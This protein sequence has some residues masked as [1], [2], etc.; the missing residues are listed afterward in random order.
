MRLE[1][2]SKFLKD[3]FA[4]SAS[5]TIGQ[6]IIFARGF[7]IRRI[8]PP[9]VMGFWNF[10][11]VVQGV[12]AAFDF[13]VIAGANRELPIIHGK[14][15]RQEETKIRSATLWSTFAQ[16]A[17]VSLGA[18]LYLWYIHPGY[19]HWELVASYVAIALFFVG[20]LDA[21]YNVFFSAAQSFSGLSKVLL[22]TRVLEGLTFPLAAY[23]FSLNGLFV[24]AVI[25]A[26]LKA[27]IFLFFGRLSHY[28][29][30]P[31]INLR[32]LKSLLAFG[33]SLRAVDFPYSFFTMASVL[34]VTKFMGIEELAIFSMARGF[35]LQVYD[36]SIQIGVVFAM[37][38]L[39]KSGSDVS[40]ETIGRDLKRY[41]YFQLLVLVPLLAW[42]ASVV[43]PLMVGLF[44]P[45]YRPGIPALV[46]ML[47][48]G[49][50]YVTNSGLTNQWIYRKALVKRG[51]SNLVAL[52]I[53]LVTLAVFWYG[54]DLRSVEAVAGATVIGYALYFIYMVV[55]VGR[56][57]WRLREVFEVAALVCLAAAWTLGVLWYSI[58]LHG[59]AQDIMDTLVMTSQKSALGLLALSP[60]VAV[61]LF[62]SKF[63]VN[64]I[65]ISR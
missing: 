32:V 38:F 44:I 19:G 12:L 36:I 61:G 20:T 6:L 26:C 8:L 29:V 5:N 49:F 64:R 54:L 21:V 14:G 50:F 65:G 18:L 42:A 37:R 11:A 7:V 17:V 52:A 62:N 4:F 10:V 34:W 9:E 45:K 28:H 57:F 16:R 15:D 22:A 30:K 35:A 53:M 55:M 27:A 47:A 41:L 63:R 56:E 2:K 46:I 58:N 25:C 3:S 39:A 43:L 59:Q 13:G 40:K 33:L 1:L 60:V 48:N 23:Y 31:S 24:A 51:F